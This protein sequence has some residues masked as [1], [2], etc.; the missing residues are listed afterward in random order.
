MPSY[1]WQLAPPPKGAPP[2]REN[3]TWT[4]GGLSDVLL[5]QDTIYGN[6]G[7]VPTH[8]WRVALPPK[9]RVPPLEIRTWLDGGLSDVL[10][11]QDT[12]YGDPGQAP[13]YWWQA[14]VPPRG[15]TPHRE[16]RTWLDALRKLHACIKEDLKEI[17]IEDM[18]YGLKYSL[19]HF[20]EEL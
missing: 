8:D 20:I 11:G 16:N 12:I 14:E 10:L 4:D 17:A 2:H 3:R 19:Q 15:S 6:P 18:E 7:Q 13:V 5:G 9:G 1:D